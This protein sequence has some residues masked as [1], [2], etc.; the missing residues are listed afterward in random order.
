[1]SNCVYLKQPSNDVQSIYNSASIFVIP[2]K[3]EGFPNVLAEAFST[4][5]PAVGFQE[6]PGVRELIIDGKNGF[7]VKTATSDDLSRALD[8]LISDSTMRG[9]MG[10]RAAEIFSQKYST[11]GAFSA[12]EKSVTVLL[13]INKKPKITSNSFLDILGIKSDPR[14]WFLRFLASNFS[15]DSFQIHKLFYSPHKFFYDSKN[16]YFRP[17]RFLFS[18]TKSY[19]L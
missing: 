6:C 16:R 5:L 7:L 9:N 19:E 12:W 15:L 14:Y 4:G 11:E 10:E 3:F 18:T 8:K 17:A 1:L 2:S 13:S